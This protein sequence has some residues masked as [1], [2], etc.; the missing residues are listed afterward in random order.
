ML[1]SIDPI[2]IPLLE[3]QEGSGNVSLNMVF[4]DLEIHGF[5]KFEIKGV[6]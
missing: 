3:I 6:K 4:K 1:P 5:N 2:K